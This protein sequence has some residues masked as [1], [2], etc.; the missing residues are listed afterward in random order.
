MFGM[1]ISLAA[2]QKDLFHFYFYEENT[3]NF[4]FT[5][6]FFVAA[7]FGFHVMFLSGKIPVGGKA[8]F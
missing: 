7:K 2:Q 1:R 4:K 5:I 3:L 6:I 8:V